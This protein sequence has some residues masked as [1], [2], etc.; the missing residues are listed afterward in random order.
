MDFWEYRYQNL[1]RDYNTTMVTATDTRLT[2]A[3]VKLYFRWCWNNIL[4]PD[5]DHP[6][7]I[8]GYISDKPRR[9]KIALARAS[10]FARIMKNF[11]DYGLGA[12][13]SYI[14]TELG[15]P[16]ERLNEE[17]SG[18][19]RIIKDDDG[20]DDYSVVWGEDVSEDLDDD[21]ES[22]KRFI[23]SKYADIYWRKSFDDDD[24]GIQ[25]LSEITAINFNQ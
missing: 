5:E 21:W 12:F 8:Y 16:I 4:L 18:L 11:E 13:Y 2:D 14:T 6:G 23:L 3:L 9:V 25:F 10:L 20:D 1:S 17:L 22:N 7:E 19:V 15:V 24:A